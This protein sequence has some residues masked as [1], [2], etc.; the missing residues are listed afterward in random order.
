MGTQRA[1]KARA[2]LT[3]K[4]CKQ[5]Y[6]AC[7]QC[8]HDKCREAFHATCARAAGWPMLMVDDPD[9]D[10]EAEEGSEEPPAA[11]AQQQLAG[12][13]QQPLQQHP[14]AGQPPLL[15]GQQQL[16]GPQQQQQQPG[17]QL[18]PQ[19]GQTGGRAPARPGAGK[20]SKPKSRKSHKSS[21]GGTLAGDNCRL[22]C[23]CP[24]HRNLAEAQQG[25]RLHNRGTTPH[26]RLQR[27][28]ISATAA[29]AGCAGHSTE[30]TPS[31]EPSPAVG[32]AA[33]AAAAVSGGG[34]NSSGSG[35]RSGSSQVPSAL[36]RVA[37]G[38]M[39]SRYHAARR[40]GVMLHGPSEKAPEGTSARSRPWDV[41]SRRHM[42]AP[43]QLAVSMR[44]RLYMQATP[45]LVTGRSGTVRQQ[46]RRPPPASSL[47]TAAQYDQ[48]QQR[49]LGAAAGGGSGRGQDGGSCVL[50]LLQERLQIQQL[51]VAG[52]REAAGRSGGGAPLS[53]A[54]RYREMVRTVNDRLCTGKS[55]IHG[56]GVFLKRPH[57][58][59]VLGGW[60]C[61]LGGGGGWHAKQGAARWCVMRCNAWCPQ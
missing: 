28:A 14:Q 12:Q 44:K 11:A 47:W 7:I 55:A 15:L 1:T 29:A 58:A 6:G 50:Q 2:G 36:A 45:H 5:S 3:C 56:T 4:V 31:R 54:E 41:S 23:Y 39:A 40:E 17:V 49:Q 53:Q 61:W 46:L 16:E 18:T 33:G 48:Q 57:K 24:R 13:H 25:V 26:T 37:T 59:G 51:P 8:A 60:L 38:L 19:Q 42:K 10:S 43:D 52:S 35:S 20:G 27:P 22:V 21:R 9:S 32:E 34:R 30:A